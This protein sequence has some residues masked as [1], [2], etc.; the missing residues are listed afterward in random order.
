MILIVALWIFFHGES[1]VGPRIVRKLWSNITTGQSENLRE[2]TDDKQGK[3]AEDN[4][5]ERRVES[6]LRAAAHRGYPEDA[7]DF[8]VAPPDCDIRQLGESWSS[9]TR[10]SGYDQ[11]LC[12]GTISSS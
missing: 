10:T 2:Q 3:Q 12:P 5:R 4:S 8:M 6:Q 1:P 11:Q 7:E 9:N